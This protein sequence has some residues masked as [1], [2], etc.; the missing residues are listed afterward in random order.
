MRKMRISERF[1]DTCANVR[2]RPI[3]ATPHAC[4]MI[5]RRTISSFSPARI[6]MR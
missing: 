5:T 2:M 4:V 1:S 6:C 3:A